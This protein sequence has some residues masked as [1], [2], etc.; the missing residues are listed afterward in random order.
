MSGW[1]SAPRMSAT[2]LRVILAKSAAAVRS[3]GRLHLPVKIML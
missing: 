1:P 2:H 3:A